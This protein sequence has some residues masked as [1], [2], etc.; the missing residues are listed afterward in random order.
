MKKIWS[1][2]VHGLTSSLPKEDNV[3]FILYQCNQ[4]Q[5]L[6]S[7]SKCSIKD[8]SGDWLSKEIVNQKKHVELGNKLLCL[9]FHH[10]PKE[11]PLTQ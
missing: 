2:F 1:N 11:T 3:Q 10:E 5:L 6:A 9:S 7:T 4:F 8:I